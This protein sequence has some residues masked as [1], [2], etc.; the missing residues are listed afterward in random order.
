VLVSHNLAV[1]EHMADRVAVMYLGRVI[2]AGP[3]ELIFGHPRHPYTETL[4]SS[5]LTP[6]THLG[7]PDLGLG[8]GFPNPLD[9]PNGCAFHPR[10][11]KA[12]SVC[13]VTRAVTQR[14]GDGLVECHLYDQEQVALPG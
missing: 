8:P 1:V 5:V 14:D 6:E 2:E 3:T 11:P 13:A 7:L 9:P 10:C 4:L 12:M